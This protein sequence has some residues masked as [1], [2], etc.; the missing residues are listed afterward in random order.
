VAEIHFATAGDLTRELVE[1]V[2]DEIGKWQDI[3][4]SQA[5]GIHPTDSTAAARFAIAD[6]TADLSDHLGISL[7]I[8]LAAYGITAGGDRG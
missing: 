4:I 3:A 1:A 8:V 7:S 5:A 6:L 2:V